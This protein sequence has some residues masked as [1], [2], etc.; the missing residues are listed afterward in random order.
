MIEVDNGI[1]NDQ[2]VVIDIEYQIIDRPQYGKTIEKVPSMI[3]I[4]EEETIEEHKIIEDKPLEGNIEVTMGGGRG[5]SRLRDRQC[6]ETF[7][8][9]DRSG[10]RSG[11]GS[12]GSPNRDRI[13]CFKCRE[14]DQFAKDCPNVT[15][16]E[17]NQTE[18]MQQMIDSEEQEDGS[19]KLIRGKNEGTTFL[20]LKHQQPTSGCQFNLLKIWKMYV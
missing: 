16:A 8:S 17:N 9:N 3:R 11:S 6:S 15:V 20:P 4:I 19:F 2:V 5:R 14:Y 18:Q 1:G 13:R 7:R 10:T 12:R